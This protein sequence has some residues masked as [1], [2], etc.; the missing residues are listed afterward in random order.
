VEELQALGLL[1][2]KHALESRGL[3]CGGS[4]EERASRL[5]SVKGLNPEQYPKKIC[6]QKK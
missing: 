6:A 3:K 1:H 4:L 5:F 2:L